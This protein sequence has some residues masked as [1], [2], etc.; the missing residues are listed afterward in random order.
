MTYR[1]SR[2]AIATLLAATATSVS[3]SAEAQFVVGDIYYASTLGEIYNITGGGDFTGQFVLDTNQYSIGQFAW[4]VDLDTM[5]LSLYA[6]GQVIAIDPQGNFTTHA[7]NL[8]GPSGLVMTRDGVLLVAEHDAGE[9]TDVTN[10]GDMGGVLPLT[11]GLMG[12]RDMVEL[13]DGTV[14][15][16]DQVLDEIHDALYPNGGA[17]GQPFAEGLNL[18]RGLTATQSGSIYA[19]I[20]VFQQGNFLHLAYDVTAGGDFMGVAP[21][22]MGQ[23]LFSLTESAD[24]KLLSGELFGFV[25]WDITG[26]GDFSGATPYATGLTEGETP[27]DT[28]PPPVCGSGVVGPGEECDDGN[29]SDEDACLNDC[30]AASCGDGFV[31]AGM[32]ECD[33]G[34]LD[35]GDGCS[36]TCETEPGGTG[37]AGGVGGSGGSGGSPMTGTTVGS[38]SST[39]G[40]AGGGGA[41][42]NANDGTTEQD[43]GCGCRTAPTPGATDRWWGVLAL[44]GL[45]LSRRR[46]R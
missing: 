45:G 25:V 10:G 43:S 44:L 41:G 40:S 21:Y 28:V 29:D 8:S 13:S 4:S 14:L 26:G 38:S 39:A 31:W 30:T 15:V 20:E 17:V 3:T 16:A 34:N 2:L 7:T 6:A 42:G 18:V 9:I 11:T 22:A 19:T 36:S 12:P 37:G 33:D 35:D 32:E 1:T 46:R 23:D 24:G 5:Y 27:L